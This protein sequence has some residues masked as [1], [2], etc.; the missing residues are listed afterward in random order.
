M[1]AKL[2]TDLPPTMN[3]IIAANRR[4][5]FAG[6]KQKKEWTEKIKL[7]AADLPAFEGKVWVTVTYVIK[8]LS[9]DCD[10]I[11]SS[12]K[13]LFDG[14]VDAGIIKGDSLR[15][16]Q[17]PTVEFFEKGESDG[18]TIIISDKPLYKLEGVE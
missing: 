1:Q 5:R 16:I 13:F 11:S 17:S 9:R 14:L 2:T 12:R 7:A 15:V 8:N 10:N 4:N 6:A 3:D 18:L